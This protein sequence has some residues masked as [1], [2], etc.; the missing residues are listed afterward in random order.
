MF[1]LGSLNPLYVKIS[2]IYRAFWHYVDH[3]LLYDESFD[4][5]LHT[6]LNFYE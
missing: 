6:Y 1:I 4:D 2:Y 3:T 5:R